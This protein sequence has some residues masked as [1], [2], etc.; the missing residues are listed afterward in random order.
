[1]R[2]LLQEVCLG[3]DPRKQEQESRE[4][5]QGRK[6][7]KGWIIQVAATAEGLQLYQDL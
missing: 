3:G 1:M 2:I 5:E 4:S 7:I 6:L